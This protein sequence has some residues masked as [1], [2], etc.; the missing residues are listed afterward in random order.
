MK[1][2]KV[3]VYAVGGCGINIV[4][5]LM[6]VAAK[7]VKGYANLTFGM[8]DTSHSN[9]PDAG[10]SSHFIHIGSRHELTDGS[11]K[12]RST[13]VEHARQ[14]VTDITSKWEPGDLNIVV[15]SGSGGS[16]SL[17]GN[18]LAKDLISKGKNVVVVMVGSRTCVKEV[19]NV[20]DTIMTY[21]KV[22]EGYQRPVPCYFLDNSM[23]GMKEVD[24]LARIMIL[25][26][27]AVWSGENKGLDR[28][29]LENFLNYNNVS[30]YQAGIVS[31]ELASGVKVLSAPAECPISTVVTIVKPEEDPSPGIMVP[32]HSYGELNEKVADRLK[33][34]TPVHLYTRQGV[35]PTVLED[36]E[37]E[38]EHYRKAS[39]VKAVKVEKDPTDDFLVI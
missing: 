21:Q 9:L 35:F 19:D 17:V 2:N 31:L 20:R 38:V 22:A 37:K 36:L 26:L 14:A 3:T 24:G 15:H 23:M 33:I 8:I 6:Q 1:E 25:F 11:G 16:G 4:T 18:I 13:N 7:D 12:V 29:D 28:K 34:A 27:S 32:Y 39:T 5:P 10:F 30:D